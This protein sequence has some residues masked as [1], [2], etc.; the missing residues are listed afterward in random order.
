SATNVTITG[1]TIIGGY[2]GITINGL[3]G[4]SSSNNIISDNMLQDFY[5]YGM[6]LRYNDNAEIIDNELSRSNR[7]SVSSFYGI[8]FLS[9]GEGNIVANN[10][11][12]SPFGG[13]TSTT[14]SACYAIYH[15]G[16]DSPVSNPGL[17]YNNIIHVGSNQNNVSHNGTIYALYN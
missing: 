10:Y 12:H 15:N 6:Y 5:Y 16:Q 9:G 7:T 3:S 1:N 4:T 11:I 17:V 13:V 2:Y 14:S 8:Y